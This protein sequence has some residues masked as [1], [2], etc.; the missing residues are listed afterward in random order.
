M[1]RGI[2]LSTWVSTAGDLTFNVLVDAWHAFFDGADYDHDDPR[3]REIDAQRV[4]LGIPS[5]Y[6]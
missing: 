3:T 6:S 1:S 4:A 2:D 5:V